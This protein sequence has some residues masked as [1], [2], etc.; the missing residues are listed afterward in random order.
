MDEPLSSRPLWVPQL[1]N[2]SIVVDSR[3]YGLG[4][5]IM[6]EC[7]VHAIESQCL[8]ETGLCEKGLR[9]AVRCIPSCSP[10]HI[11]VC[12]NHFPK[13][14]MIACTL[15]PSL[16]RWFRIGQLWSP[17]CFLRFQVCAHCQVNAY[18]RM[19]LHPQLFFSG[20]VAHK[21][22]LFSLL[23]TQSLATCLASFQYHH[24]SYLR[25]FSA[26]L[27][28]GDPLSVFLQT[29]VTTRKYSSHIDVWLR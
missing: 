28:L 24:L 13:I 23:L 4:L 20:L 7:I 11:L 22:A 25:Y 14:I 19:T 12:S 9:S 5:S 3:V 18:G 16:R 26:A 17:K 27:S 29:T 1:V 8:A 15:G 21:A 10:K 6:M 2:K